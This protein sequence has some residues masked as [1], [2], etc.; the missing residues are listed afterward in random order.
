MK[1]YMRGLSKSLNLNFCFKDELMSYGFE[2]TWGGVNDDR[3]LNVSVT[4]S[5]P[6]FRQL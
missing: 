4:F 6:V 1:F 2:T 5:D 3:I